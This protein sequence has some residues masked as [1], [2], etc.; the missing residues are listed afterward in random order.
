MINSGILTVFGRRYNPYNVLVAGGASTISNVAAMAAAVS[1]TSAEV[2]YFEIRG[3][4]VYAFIIETGY[5]CIFASVAAF[6]S[7]PNLKSVTS[8]CPR[9]KTAT[10]SVFNSCANLEF[11]DL[12]FLTSCG[13]NFLRYCPLL[14]VDK[15]RLP[16][17]KSKG[18]E[19]LRQTALWGSGKT[20]NLPEFDTATANDNTCFANFRGTINLP[21]LLS[22]PNYNLNNVFGTINIPNCTSLGAA[23]VNNLVFTGCDSRTIINIKASMAT[24]NAGAPDADLV[25]AIS[26]GS[27]VNY[28]P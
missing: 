1:V 21:K 12:P 28:I 2:M 6:N 5:D 26:R 18:F 11:V 17:L 3:N 19:M 24:I 8:T 14:D 13:S 23:N 16:K 20:L 15:V 4:D 27:T 25:Y 9:I 7:N 10:G 22:I